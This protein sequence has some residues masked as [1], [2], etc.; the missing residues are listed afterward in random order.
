[1]NSTVRSSFAALALA[2][3]GLPALA[4]GSPRLAIT[5]P[6]DVPGYAITYNGS[7]YSGNSHFTPQPGHVLKATWSNVRGTSGQMAAELGRLRVAEFGAG[8]ATAADGSLFGVGGSLREASFEDRIFVQGAG[9][10]ANTVLRVDYHFGGTAGGR[11]ETNADLGGGGRLD[12]K[13]ELLMGVG[14]QGL[15]ITEQT[16]ATHDVLAG[17]QQRTRLASDGLFDVTDTGFSMRLGEA[18]FGSYLFDLNWRLSMTAQCLFTV[19]PLPPHLP[20]PSGGCSYSADYGN[21][22]SVM[23]MSLYD[24]SSGALLDPASY[25]LRSASGFDYAQGFDTPPVP[26]PQT[27]ALMVLGLGLLARRLR[28]GRECPLG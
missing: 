19:A 18:S 13:A 23:G 9:L 6:L 11:I 17:G 3:A 26:E 8:R 1:M 15:R 14:G 25:S 20:S 16:W 24:G 5:P 27:W 21:T 10:T 12:I 4:A 28:A 7:P 22:A 2:L